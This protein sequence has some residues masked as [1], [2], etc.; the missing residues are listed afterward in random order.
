[1]RVHLE[2]EV[3]RQLVEPPKLPRMS[4]QD[5]FLV[6]ADTR[7]AADEITDVGAYAEVVGAPNVDSDQHDQGDPIDGTN[8]RGNWPAAK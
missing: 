2:A 6:R 7:K 5:V 3:R 1:M 4:D 8:A